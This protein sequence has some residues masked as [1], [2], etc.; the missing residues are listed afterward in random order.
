MFLDVLL[1]IKCQL[2][3]KLMPVSGNVIVATVK[4]QEDG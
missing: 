1:T 4:R 2:Y 3:V